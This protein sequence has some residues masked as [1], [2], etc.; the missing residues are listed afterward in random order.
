MSPQADT[1]QAQ[2][3]KAPRVS[4]LTKIVYGSGD[5]GMSSFGTLRQIFYAVFL[6]D[7]V[8]LDVRPASIAALVGVVRDAVNDPLVGMISDRTRT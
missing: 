6:T 1:A 8:G 3:A 2:V 7:A 5:W 4:F